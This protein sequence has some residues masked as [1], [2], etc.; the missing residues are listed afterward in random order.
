MA[1][2]VV[3]DIRIAVNT[4]G[5]ERT[6]RALELAKNEN[7]KMLLIIINPDRLKTE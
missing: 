7:K 2:T 4:V 1:C 6:I 3:I 5:Y